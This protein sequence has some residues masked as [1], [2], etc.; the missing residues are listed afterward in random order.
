MG[1]QQSTTAL[2]GAFEEQFHSGKTEVLSSGCT[3]P[4]ADT[5][6][7]AKT[8]MIWM[9]EATAIHISNSLHSFNS[10]TTLVAAIL[11]R[12]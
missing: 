6:F 5:V 11:P 8:T 3:K 10:S 9:P 7:G 2:A 4:S 12:Q 1:A